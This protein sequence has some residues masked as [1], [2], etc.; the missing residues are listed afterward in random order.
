MDNKKVIEKLID[1]YRKQDIEIIYRLLAN[2]QIDFN[3]LDNMNDLPEDEKVILL[4][5]IKLN[6]AE[7]R[8]FIRQE[9][10]ETP[11]TF[12]NVE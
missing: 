7:L 11:L 3:R 9:K 1:Y 12:S 8:K 4:T 10:D 6:S 2:C 5:R